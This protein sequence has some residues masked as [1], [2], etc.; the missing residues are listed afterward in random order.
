MQE[1]VRLSDG[2][3][4]KLYQRADGS[5]YYNN[6]GSRVTLRSNQH[7]VRYGNQN[8]PFSSSS[9]DI[10]NYSSLSNSTSDIQPYQYQGTSDLTRQLQ[11][12]DN[13]LVLERLEIEE[14]NKK[15]TEKEKEL[16]NAKKKD[17]ELN[18]KLTEKELALEQEKQER[19]SVEDKMKEIQAKMNELELERKKKIEVMPTKDLQ[20][21]LGLE[22]RMIKV[23]I[24]NLDASDTKKESAINFLSELHEQHKPDLWFIT[25]TTKCKL[26]WVK[27]YEEL[28]D[29][30]GQFAINE[31]DDDETKTLA[32]EHIQIVWN[33]NIF[34][35]GNP[36]F[37]FLK[38]ESRSLAVQLI[39]QKT[40]KHISVVAVHLRKGGEPLKNNCIKL[41]DNLKNY[42]KNPILI[43]GDFNMNVKK[44]ENFKTKL[45]EKYS[46]NLKLG[47]QI[48]QSVQNTLLG[49]FTNEHS[50]V[51]YSDNLRLS[52]EIIV[53]P[54][55]L[56]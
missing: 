37:T 11:E 54:M 1:Y 5:H 29:E 48:P 18:K 36:S 43:A 25:E 34:K 3:E 27:K 9:N 52:H 33:T 22:N 47:V 21:N 49:D 55:R 20:Q 7:V 40:Q 51:H 13:Q 28:Q 12:K 16:A 2:R 50:T 41:E 53:L 8:S 10:Q 19:K 17:K 38:D 6:K 39:H 42:I 56:N 14:L 26:S 35:K 31:S 44:L 45:N 30:C 46:L 24:I 15:L 32:S 4:L 23:L